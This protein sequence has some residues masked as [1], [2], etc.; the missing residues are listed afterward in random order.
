M[1]VVS[2]AQVRS[3]TYT[4]PALLAGDMVVLF[5][6]ADGV[7]GRDGITEPSGWA[8]AG[9]TVS[10]MVSDNPVSG[11]AAVFFR[12]STAAGVVSASFAGQ[13]LKSAPK[14]FSVVLRGPTSIADIAIE[15]M[16]AQTFTYPA[17]DFPDPMTGHVLHAALARTDYT[18]PPWPSSGGSELQSDRLDVTGG[19]NMA[20]QSVTRHLWMSVSER[21][22]T[23]ATSVPA[24]AT[25]QRLSGW[26]F[27]VVAAAVAG[28]AAPEVISPQAGSLDLAAGFLLEWVPS[29]VQ[30]G[31]ALR[32]RSPTIAGN[33]WRWFTGSDWSATT[34][35]VITGD[36]QAIAWGSGWFPNAA[37]DIDIATRGD[38]LRPELGT[39]ARISVV[40]KASP[41]APT[42][43]IS[44]VSGTSL[45]SFTPT[46]TM[47]G[48]AGSGASFTGYRVELVQ[49]GA[50]V[51][52]TPAPVASPY[53]LP[54]AAGL[55]LTN[56]APVTI[57]AAVV[58]DGTMVGPYVERTYDLAVP[59]P[60]APVVEVARVDHPVSFAPGF[61][62]TVTTNA[63]GHL[64]LFRDGV[65]VSAVIAGAGVPREFFDY[66]APTNVPV[67]YAA[68]VQTQAPIPVTSPQGVADPIALVGEHDWLLDLAHPE[69]A[70]RVELVADDAVSVETRAQEFAVIGSSAWLYHGGVPSGPRGAMTV[71][72]RTRQDRDRAVELLTSGR[73]LLLRGCVEQDVRNRDVVDLA[74]DRRFHVVG[75][76][77]SARLATGPWSWREVS[78]SWI[79]AKETI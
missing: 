48:S 68:S 47:A 40:G 67:V 15:R 55:A 52:S 20:G 63:T 71:R 16:N 35:T 53:A 59:T 60:A 58:Q 19:R 70:V 12:R 33:A 73:L 8:S 22:I 10:Q 14:V 44:N 39:Y 28:P 72:T 24:V 26:A 34:E 49:A 29:G 77:T 23:S 45:T 54:V 78:F 30:T 74:T 5:V 27:T 57:R 25:T 6:G 79:D 31:Y 51:W 18:I 56:G 17:A 21:P 37:F 69:T 65:L 42:L 9:P 11:S 13:G 61:R 46:L 2:S 43:T 76:V 3:Y 4:S 62:V 7:Y 66:G 36:E 75:E 38:A 41:A 64:S 1:T 50:V 32:R